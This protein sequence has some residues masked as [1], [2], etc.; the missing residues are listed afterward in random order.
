M[1]LLH[2]ANRFSSSWKHYKTQLCVRILWSFS[3]HV[4]VLGRILSC[5]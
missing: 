4:K 5:C 2:S 1:V 3:Y